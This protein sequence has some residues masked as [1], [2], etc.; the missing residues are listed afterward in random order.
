MHSQRVIKPTPFG[1]FYLARTTMIDEINIRLPRR[2]RSAAAL[3]SESDA[4]CR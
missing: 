3:H 4:D 1:P 2:R